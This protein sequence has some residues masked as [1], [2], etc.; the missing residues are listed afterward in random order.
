MARIL[1]VDDEPSILSFVQ[2]AMRIAGHQ[3]ETASNAKAALAACDA[4]GLPDLLLTD[5]KMPEMDGDVLAAQ[6]RQREPDLKVLYLTGYADQ[7]FNQRGNLWRSEAFLEKPC[8]VQG[9]LEAVSMM[10]SGQYDD[11]QDRV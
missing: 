6:L 3:T 10:L 2:K 11:Y 4:K 7:L 9:L 5:Y 1:I 8:T